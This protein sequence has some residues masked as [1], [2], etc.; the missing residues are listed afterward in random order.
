[1]IGICCG[2]FTSELSD[3]ERG[4]A[5]WVG[6]TSSGSLLVTLM[7]GEEEEE[8]KHTPGLPSL[9]PTFRY[10]HWSML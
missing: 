3:G 5:G 1:M 8:W 2:F 10:E 9:S 6:P 4:L 7:D